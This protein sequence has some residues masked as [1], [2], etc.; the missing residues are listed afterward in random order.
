MSK[1]GSEADIEPCRVNVAEVP[2][3]DIDAPIAP[4]TSQGVASPRKQQVCR[5]GAVLVYSSPR[6][7]SCSGWSGSTALFDD[8][9]VGDNNLL[10]IEPGRRLARR[11]KQILTTGHLHELRHPVASGHQGST[12]SIMAPR[13]RGRYSCPRIV[14]TGVYDIR[15]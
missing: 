11:A 12:H 7:L 2:L 9:G 6:C 15:Q 3:T 10:P 4:C 5:Q 1:K 14:L 13:C 8:I